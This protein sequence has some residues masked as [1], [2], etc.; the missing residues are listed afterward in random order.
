MLSHLRVP[1]SIPRAHL[2]PWFRPAQPSCSRFISSSRINRYTDLS[3]E[4]EPEQVAAEDSATTVQEEPVDRPDAGSYREFLET[5]GA[6]YKHATCKQW[7]GGNVPFPLN[8]SFK[9]PAPVPDAVRS[10]IYHD[11]MV[12]PKAETIRQLAR[13][14]NISL[15]RVD[16]ILRLKGM[17]ADWVKGK[18]L[19]T[20][21]Q[22]G[23]EN[24]LGVNQIHLEQAYRYDAH[25]ADTLEEEE[26]RDAARQRY[27][28]LYWES[29]PEDGREPV[30]PLNLE[31]AK[32]KAKLMA[33]RAEE[34]KSD[35]ELMPLIQNP[36]LFGPRPPKTLVSKRSGHP[37]IQFVDVGGK[38]IDP[39]DRLHRMANA[40]RNRR[41]RLPKK[42]K[43]DKRDK[44]GR[45][46]VST[47][48][49]V[50]PHVA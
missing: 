50:P 26:H 44:K 33:L 39:K 28:R 38:Y 7:L 36:K 10:K 2:R 31:R 46:D 5:I 24:I 11:Y 42:P 49:H 21:F 6:Q 9:P 17:E 18:P 47:T 48:K 43:K 16:A 22:F 34:R 27:Q 41:E 3:P 40:Q 4:P 8:P 37:T 14:H 1:P 15:K 19:Q 30:V 35:R 20:G 29:V 12:N 32:T 23:M 25:E 13:T 45:K